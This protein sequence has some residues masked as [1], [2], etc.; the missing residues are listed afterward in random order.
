MLVA[1]RP[2]PAPATIAA[3]DEHGR[4]L[5]AFARVGVAA[6]AAGGQLAAC[7]AT[8]PSLEEAADAPRKADAPTGARASARAC[9][10]PAALSREDSALY[11]ADS[12]PSA[13]AEHR[14]SAALVQP[15][16]RAITFVTASHAQPVAAG[17]MDS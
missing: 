1:A 16:A 4:E 8:Q 9:R 10:C 5:G 13:S 11:A 14:A 7:E 3:K 6:R 12:A 15:D 17:Q 2:H